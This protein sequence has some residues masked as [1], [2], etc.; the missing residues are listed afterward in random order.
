MIKS[1]D[2]GL[3]W[4][5]PVRI[6]MDP[7]GQG[8]S[9]YFPWIHCDQANGI[10]SI[11]F[12]DN[13]NVSNNQCE[14]WLAWSFDG[15]DTWEEMKVSDVAWT[16]S[17]I[18][19]MAGGYFGDYIGCAGYSGRTYPCW[20]DNRGGFAMAYVSPIDLI[21][22]AAAVL[23]N[24][25]Y[26]NDTTFGNGNGLV[27]YD[28]TIL[29]GL[30][31]TN[32]GNIPADS[33]WVTLSTTSPFVAIE[34]SSEYF[35][36]FDVSESIVIMDAFKF[37]TTPTIPDGYTISFKVTATDAADTNYVSYFYIEAHAPAVTILGMSIADPTGNNNNRLDPG[38]QATV[39][40]LTKNTGDYDA[41]EVVSTL[42]SSNPFVTVND[43]TYDIGALT[44]GQSVY[45]EFPVSVNAAAA[46]GSA[47]TLH[48]I[49]QSEYHMD[50]VYETVKIGLLVEDWE[51]GNFQKFAWTFG[52]DAD[53]LIDPDV[54]WEGNYSAKSGTIAENQ[55]SELVINYHV[56][57]NDSISFYRKV[58]SQGLSDWLKL[59]IDGMV[60]GM[61]SGNQDWQ[62]FAYPV[63]AGPHEFKWVYSKDIAG[64]FGSDCA[65]VD[66]IVFPPEYKT[67]AWAGDDASVC[68]GSSY[69]LN[70]A[71]VNYDTLFW[72]T[73]GTGIFSD[74]NSFNP[75]YTPSPDDIAAGS[76]VLTITASSQGFTPMTDE[77]TLTI[78]PALIIAAGSDASV[79]AGNDYALAGATGSNYVSVMWATSG[80][81]V[82]SDPALLN[83]F[84]TPGQNDIATGSVE[85]TLDAISGN[86]CPDESD[87]LTLSVL[88]V[89]SVD[90]GP[91]TAIC[92]QFTYTLDATTPDAINYLWEPGG[93]TTPTITVDSAGIGIGSRE[94]TVTVTVSNGCE[95]IDGSVVTFK[96]C[97]G[98]NE[99][100]QRVKMNIYPNPNPGTFT[101]ELSTLRPVTLSLRILNASGEEVYI[102]RGM[103]VEGNTKLPLNP[104]NLSQGG[105]L[106]EI[107]DS[108]DVIVARLVIRK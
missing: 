70:S 84:Y 108:K 51:T 37:H 28:E 33:V 77:M 62:R 25:D 27:D 101:I 45:A 93:E 48:N 41:L 92:A 98:I 87:T 102:K 76:V 22:P 4:S 78:H 103:T 26:I 65:W 3:T 66:F 23:Y 29:L 95:G 96:T 88:P 43:G 86:V 13:R 9:H 46:I 56:M 58:S 90:L 94:Y 18:P 75:E 57:L 36:D 97:A 67:A 7:I 20:T 61:W 34:D 50:E 31:M 106:V 49:A 72:T 99:L 32:S 55:T 91:D 42:T 83:P 74:P 81:G 8:K 24:D 38:E 68:E 73:S 71:A 17:P 104:G 10:L 85:L 100:S 30:E 2:E 35:G 60:V 79:C 15:G 54:K 64:S 53:W 63:L 47:T 16:P 89:P 14:T 40:F 105:Y 1:T 52:G 12:Y 5:S 82:F 44:P 11:A 6:N 69:Q 39:K 19:G 21:I 59:Y 107:S 80:D